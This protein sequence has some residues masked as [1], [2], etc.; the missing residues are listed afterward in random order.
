MYCRD[1]AQ[2]TDQDLICYYFYIFLIKNDCSHFAVTA[3]T[4]VLAVHKISK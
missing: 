4:A 2:M 1:G 3:V